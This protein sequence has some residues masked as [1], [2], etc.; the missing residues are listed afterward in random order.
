M[1]QLTNNP[2]NVGNQVKANGG[3]D[4]KQKQHEPI[5]ASFPRQRRFCAEPHG[6]GSDKQSDMIKFWQ[7]SLKLQC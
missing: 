6:N 3:N 1:S 7:Y 4:V 2:T 5:Q